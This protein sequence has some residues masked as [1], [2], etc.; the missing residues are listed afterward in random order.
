MWPKDSNVLTNGDK[1]DSVTGASVNF[2]SRKP[3]EMVMKLETVAIIV[4]VVLTLGTASDAYDAYRKSSRW[5]T[6]F[7]AISAI[8]FALAAW[9]FL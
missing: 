8:I 6:A 4:L 2:L 3:W 1:N 9:S 5:R 7:S